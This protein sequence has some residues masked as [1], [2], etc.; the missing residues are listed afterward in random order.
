MKVNDWEDLAEWLHKEG[1]DCYAELIWGAPGETVESFMHGYDR[2]SRHVSRIAV[3]PILLLP[4][5]DYAEKKNEYGIVS[6]RGDHDDF[7]YVLAHDPMTFAENQLMQRFLYWSRVL[8][9]AAVLRLSWVALRELGSVSQ[10]KVLRSMDDWIGQTDNPAAAVLRESVT[11]G[12]AAPGAAIAFLYR[13]PQAKRLL[14]RWWEEAVRPNLPPDT[15]PLLDEVFRYDLLTQPIHRI[16][17]IP[18]DED[19]SV[20]CVGGEQ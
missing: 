19:V 5:T 11:M 17:G 20:V 8:A 13:D 6:V 3:Y 14:S 12:T 7:E 2:L 9:D 18:L 15:A 4:N 16:A 1:L 10:S